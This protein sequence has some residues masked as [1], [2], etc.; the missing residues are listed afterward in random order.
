M[1]SYYLRLCCEDVRDVNKIRTFILIILAQK[2]SIYGN[3]VYFISNNLN[4]ENKYNST[5]LK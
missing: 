3:K 5:I 2:T 1:A 4:A